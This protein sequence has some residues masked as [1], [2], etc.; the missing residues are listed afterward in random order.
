LAGEFTEYWGK[1]YWGQGIRALGSKI[2]FDILFSLPILILAYLITWRLRRW[3]E[4][5][6]ILD[7]PNERSSHTLPT[8]RGGGLAIVFFTLSGFLA[9]GLYRPSGS[10]ATVLSYVAG[11]FIIAG[12]GWLDDLR[13]LPN[14]IRFGFHTVAAVLILIGV[15]YWRG[16][17]LPFAGEVHFGWVGFVATLLWITGL[18]N[19]YN[20]MDGIDGIAGG[21]AVIA[22]L[23]WAILGWMS[24]LPLLSDLGLL[25]AASSLGFLGHN[26]PPARI[27]MGDVGSAFLGYTFAALAVIAAQSDLRFGLA[28]VIVIWPF[29]FDTLFTFFRRW[30]KS[31]NVFAPHRSHLYQRLVIIKYTHRFVTL[32]YMGLGAV[33]VAL[34]MAWWARVP[35]NDI[36]LV[37]TIPLL[38]LCLW[39]FVVWSEKQSRSGI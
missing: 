29:V 1:L 26:W 28:G 10:F 2:T 31:E 15:G 36:L 11:S 30:R 33:G 4:H 34:A 6:G 5:R 27:F 12:A 24:H 9:I 22:G 39:G 19:S 13:S 7:I 16:M 8:P 17:D 3:A 25:V 32:L 23:G 35:G 38:C 21:Q 37:V 14:W 20:F 18:T